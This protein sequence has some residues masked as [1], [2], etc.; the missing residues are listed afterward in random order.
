MH[1]NGI[2]R[3]ILDNYIIAFLS[4]DEEENII[5]VESGRC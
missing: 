5:Q 2:I 3:A 1:Q 4:H